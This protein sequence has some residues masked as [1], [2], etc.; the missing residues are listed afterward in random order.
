MQEQMNSMNNS[1]EFQEVKS[2]HSGRLS[3]VSSQPAVIPSSRSM[4]NRDKRLPLDTWNTS[5]LQDNVFGNQFSTF[6][7]PRDHNQGIHSC[8]PQ[9]ERG[10]VPQATGSGTL[11]ERDDK[12]NRDTM[13]M[14]TFAG[15]PSTM[16]SLIPVDMPKIPMVGQQR[17][18]ISPSCN[19]TNHPEFPIEEEGLSRGAESPQRGSLS[20]RKTDRL[21]FYDC[22][23]VTGAHD[24][25]L[26]CADLF[27][28]TLRNDDVHD[29]DTKWD[30]IL[31]SMLKIPSDDIFENLYKLRIRESAQLKTVLELSDM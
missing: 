27:T 8:A 6:D 28:S 12:Q 18:Q 11:F 30:E 23:R 3:Y 17:Q 26:D 14:S 13:P 25:V 9:R 7:S 29:F 16:S 22:F 19:S 24:T 21:H 15:R 4:L 20:T 1:G 31:L 10:L 5:G 2:N